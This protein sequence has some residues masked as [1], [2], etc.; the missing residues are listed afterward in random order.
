MSTPQRTAPKTR[1]L[2]LAVAAAA[3]VSTLA[4]CSPDVADADGQ[5]VDSASATGRRQADEARTEAVAAGAQ[6]VKT[7]A[8]ETEAVVNKTRDAAITASIRSE[9]S[10]DRQLRAQVIDVDTAGG[11]VLLRGEAPDDAARERATRLAAGVDGVRSVDNLL[12]VTPKD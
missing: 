7:S 8:D 9:F 5:K 10:K 6:A 1:V 12:S 2:L 4:V 11:R 3:A